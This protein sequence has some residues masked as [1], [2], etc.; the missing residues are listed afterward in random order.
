MAVIGLMNQ[1][2][3]LE[4]KRKWSY[5]AG[6]EFAFCSQSRLQVAE[7]YIGTQATGEDDLA[8]KLNLDTGMTDWPGALLGPHENL[9]KRAG[10][11]KGCVNYLCRYAYIP[12]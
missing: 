2:S 10:N 5:I 8:E 7:S 4:L 3:V 6:V 11:A 1:F 9:K 12:V